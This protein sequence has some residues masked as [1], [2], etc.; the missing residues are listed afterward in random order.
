MENPK[1]SLDSFNF[2]CSVS[3]DA[4]TKDLCWGGSHE[5][6]H[7][8]WTGDC[9]QSICVP[10]W[11]RCIA[12]DNCKLSVFAFAW[13]K[14]KLQLLFCAMFSRTCGNEIPP[15]TQ[16]MNA[17]PRA[18]RNRCHKVW[19]PK[20]AIE[21]NDV[22]RLSCHRLSYKCWPAAAANQCKFDGQ[23]ICKESGSV[24]LRCMEARSH[25]SVTCDKK[26]TRW[27]EVKWA[28]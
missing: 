23:V 1:F 17:F 5:Y 24:Q 19:T 15:Q 8:I 4:R 12:E 9:W 22:V 7:L 10:N 11:A 26:G 28:A 3:T 25:D 21:M 20:R 18:Q 16:L 2:V 6:R 13:Q 14:C 27:S